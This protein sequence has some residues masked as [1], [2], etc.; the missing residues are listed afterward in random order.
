MP[1]APSDVRGWFANCW[2]KEFCCFYIFFVFPIKEKAFLYLHGRCVFF[3]AVATDRSIFL[4]EIVDIVF[5]EIKINF[6]WVRS[7]K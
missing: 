7:Q 5:Y 4:H 1:K 2:E 6:S 3:N